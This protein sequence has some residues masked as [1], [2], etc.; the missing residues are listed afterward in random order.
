VNAPDDLRQLSLM[1]LFRVESENQTATLTA[2]LLELER[3]P[4]SS[5]PLEVLMRAA[6]SLKG[7]ARI[8][9]LNPAV[10]LAHALEDCFVALQRGQL[11]LDAARMDALFRG[12]DLLQ[13]LGRCPDAERES[14]L[15]EQASHWEASV[16]SLRNPISTTN[17]A[18]SPSS[19]QSANPP[20][21]ASADEM[22]VALPTAPETT[23]PAQPAPTAHPTT[24]GLPDLPER[25]LRLTAENLNRLLGLAGEAL[26]ESRWLRPFALNMQRLKRQHAEI[27][28]DLARTAGALREVPGAENA[29][30]EMQEFNTQL[31][32]CRS[33]LDER[34]AEL[35]RFDQ[36]SAQLS[37]R[38]Y[39]EVLRTRMRP[40]SDG[41]RRF[42]RMIRDL[43]QSLGKEVHLEIVG[44]HT[45]VDRDILE[46]L[47]TPLAH[48][49]RNAVDHGCEPPDVRRQ[50][51]KA[52]VAT[53]RL[54]ARHSAGQLVV[55]VTDDGAGVDLEAVRAVILHK[56]LA[57]P[58][59]AQSLSEAELLE[60]LFLPGVTLREQ[61]TEVS[62]RGVGL[63]IVQDLVKSVRGSLR[64]NSQPGRGT[65]FQLQLPLT[66]SVLR[67]LLVEI[68]GEAYAFPLGRLNRVLH[69]SRAEVESLEGHPHFRLQNETVGLVMAH[70]ILEGRPPPTLGDTLA[71]VVLGN[72]Q[73]QF[74][75]VVD[76]FLGERELVV[77]P[78]DPRL[79]KVKDISAAALL[80]DGA[81]V[82]I[83]DPD[84]VVRSVAKVLA[85][86]GAAGL[87]ARAPALAAPRRKRVLV[88]DDSLT[89]RELERKLLLNRGYD[90]EVAVDGMD[91]W[92][93][94]RTGRFDLVITDVDMPRLDGIELTRLVRSDPRLESLP[95]MIVSYKDRDEDRLRGLEAGADYYLT[96]SGF[97]DERLLQAVVDLIGEPE[98]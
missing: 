52:P 95:V 43:A 68:S 41:V 13:N 8:V 63:D 24:G 79:G 67:A 2:G 57:A 26:V 3:Q 31:K 21:P 38:L 16:N 91:G 14:W 45:Q 32:E 33:F 23:A 22:P 20:T 98:M 46:K 58:D 7:A 12:V 87:G 28:A 84:D 96:K 34:L 76:R 10:R 88:V 72:R 30:R 55:M 66:L 78:L 92:N 47:E 35:D 83:V 59:V 97:H 48:L 4:E 69:L 51:G 50:Q 90:A 81:P 62:G 74:G 75:L 11:R 19:P 85:E 39:L 65:R 70:E 27:E 40:F 86:G 49:L 93:A 82:L 54:E 15:R 61:V 80:E 73:E 18:T 37:H 60:F 6:H 5:A 17:V 1:E 53:V 56:R 9:G 44:E 77:Q 42:P 36:R 25:V 29:L 94:A 71:V 89:V 64:V